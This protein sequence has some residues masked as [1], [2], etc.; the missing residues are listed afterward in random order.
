MLTRE[1]L[2]IEAARRYT[3]ARE[4]AKEDYF[5]AMDKAEAAFVAETKQASFGH[6]N[7]LNRMDQVETPVD[8]VKLESA[9]R[10][11]E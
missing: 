4:K 10:A 1:S 11:A 5:A 9:I 2:I 7:A 8:L 6:R 3:L